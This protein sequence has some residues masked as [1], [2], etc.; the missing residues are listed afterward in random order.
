MER[1]DAPQAAA[2]TVDFCS[3]AGSKWTAGDHVRVSTAYGSYRISGIGIPG[4]RGDRTRLVGPNGAG[5][6]T[7]LKL[8]AGVLTRRRGAGPGAEG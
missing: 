2:A 5:K 1:I 7:L 3:A 6:S 8:L 4:R